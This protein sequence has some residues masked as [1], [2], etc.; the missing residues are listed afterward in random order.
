M[1]KTHK[2]SLQ[3]LREKLSLPQRLVYKSL[4][5]NITLIRSRVVVSLGTIFFM[6]FSYVDQRIFPLDHQLE[7]LIMRIIV[8][9]LT[10]LL[11]ILSY[12]EKFKNN[13]VW[14]VDLGAILVIGGM[15]FVVS[16]TDGA[17][18]KYYEGINQ[19]M[20]AWLLANSFYYK[21][22]I[23]V[24]VLAF[25]MY[26]TACLYNHEFWNLSKFLYSSSLI[27]ITSVYIIL[28][29]KFYESEF[30]YGFFSN[31]A[32]KESQ[33]KLAETNEK[34]ETLYHRADRMSKTDDLTKIYN[35]RY[36][37]EILNE[38]VKK[39]QE[40][41]SFFYLIIFDIDHFK[42]INDTFGHS[43]GD[44]VI[45]TVAQT[46]VQNLRSDSYIGRYGGD[47]FMLIIDRADK[48]VFFERIEH[49]RNAIKNAKI[50]GG[51]I[52][53]EHA[54]KQFK[55]S[56]SVGA[57]KVDPHKYSGISSVVDLADSALLKVKQTKR[58][59]INLIE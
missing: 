43:V 28:I 44:E 51:S 49:I 21:H 48:N 37:L 10:M 2:E 4:V 52:K 12:V 1:M 3:N 13:I 54:G 7:F 18:G 36:F 58:G 41:N 6:L 59:E 29:A 22:H 38:K 24:A 55:I 19:S 16:K 57:V 25:I 56:V 15:C 53:L 47:E 35:R 32:L 5:N 20:L 30:F 11:Y 42:E 8:C 17:S 23:G 26:T 34:L 40:E 14:L 50:G 31:E 45:R 39:C 9:S 33:K 27:A 46:V